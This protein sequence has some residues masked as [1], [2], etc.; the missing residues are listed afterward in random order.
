MDFLETWYGW[1]SQGPLHVLRN[2]CQ[3]R[4]GV[5]SM[6]GQNR[7][8]GAFLK[9]ISSE[10]TAIA[11]KRMHSNDLEACGRKCCYFW[12]HSEVIF[13]TCFWRPFGLGSFC[14]ILMLFLVLLFLVPFWSHIFDMFLTSF[15]TWVI[16]PYFNVIS[17]DFYTVKCLIN[18]YFVKISM[19]VSGRMLI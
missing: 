16:L 8:R 7:L 17:I 4:P 13:L 9:I 18:I 15:W 11:K 12:F 5:D 19:F 2:L 3:I 14:L 6:R 1:R 10:P